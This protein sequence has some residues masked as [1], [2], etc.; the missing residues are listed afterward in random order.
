MEKDIC[1][2]KKR[3]DSGLQ[4][5]IFYH[6]SI[7]DDSN[8]V[9]SLLLSK[10]EKTRSAATNDTG[11]FLHAA[12]HQPRPFLLNHTP[13][14]SDYNAHAKWVQQSHYYKIMPA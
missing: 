10:I 9:L 11:W 4:C 5:M 12:D 2:T 7:T 8:T 14:F 13:K 3:R 6:W 1:V